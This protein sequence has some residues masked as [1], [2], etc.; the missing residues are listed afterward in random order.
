MSVIATAIFSELHCS[1]HAVSRAA[2]GCTCYGVSV[3]AV[4]PLRCG[5]DPQTAT[6]NVHV[7]RTTETFLPK[8]LPSIR[9]ISAVPNSPVSSGRIRSNSHYR[10]SRISDT[11]SEGSHH[12]SGYTANSTLG[13]ASASSTVLARALAESKHL[14]PSCSGWLIQS[15]VITT[16][17]LLFGRQ[18]LRS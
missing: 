16:L 2:N 5:T 1:T 6:T 8:C 11:R 17:R 13:S 12:H 15:G 14:N 18:G 4:P 7:L 3:S 10:S 9:A